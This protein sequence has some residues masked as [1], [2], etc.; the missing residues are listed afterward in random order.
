MAD[1]A[2]KA[3][4]AAQS[5]VGAPMSTAKPRKTPEGPPK[6]D[7]NPQQNEMMQAFLM[8]AKNELNLVPGIGLGEKAYNPVDGINR[9]NAE[10]A[11]RK[12]RV[13]YALNRV[14]IDRPPALDRQ[15]MTPMQAMMLIRRG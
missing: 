7:L 6:S 14:G 10:K 3:Q 13:E 8:A 1:P 2:N 12:R 4:A 5:A 15:F 11:D 9:Y